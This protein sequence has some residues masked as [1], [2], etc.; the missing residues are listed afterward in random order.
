MEAVIISPNLLEE[1][2]RT[3]GH[4]PGGTQLLDR[5]RETKDV[6]AR[7]YLVADHLP[8]V[9]RLCQRF[10][11]SGESLEDLFQVGTIGLLKAID[12]YNPQLGNNFVAFAIPVIVG[13]IKNYFRDH[14]WAVKLPRKLQTRKLAVDRTV[15]SLTQMLG[16]TPTVPEIGE[17]T[18]F[19]E[20]E[21]YETF[22][23]G[24]Y[25][26]PLSLDLEY[27]G[28]GGEETSSILDCLGSVDPE[29]EGLADKID[30]KAAFGCLNAREEA[31]IYLRFYADLSQ[32]EI[33]K[34]LG[35][36]QMHVSRLQRNAL[37]KL[38]LNLMNEAADWL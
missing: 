18:G 7:D 19:S 32:T 11:H 8:L 25:G 17:A 31:I 27:E 35:I 20:E 33:A 5:W 36:S 9:R 30:L 4:V 21:V 34:R 37:D 13:E 16:R 12:K 10:S 29:L 26:K 15:G 14:G 23:V 6:A 38:K 1:K 22:E 24:R 28:Y 3:N 2:M